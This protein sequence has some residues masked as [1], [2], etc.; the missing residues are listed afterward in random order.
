MIYNF[1][2]LEGGIIKYVNYCKEL[3]TD[4][5]R[6][7]TGRFIGSLV[8]DFHRNMLKGGIFIYP[9]TSDKPEGQLR[10]IYECNPIALIA[11]N[12]N[13]QATNLEDDILNI[14]PLSIH[15]RTAFVVGSKKMVDKLLAFCN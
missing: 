1:N 12:S 15:Q 11:K 4:G 7:H 8:A 14:T 3:N 5:K 10:L 9:K 13:G 2:S 6:T